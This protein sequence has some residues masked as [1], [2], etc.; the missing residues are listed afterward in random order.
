MVT[1]KKKKNNSNGMNNNCITGRNSVWRTWLVTV[2]SPD[3][4]LEP[5]LFDSSGFSHFL[6]SYNY[7]SLKAL[8]F[9]ECHCV[10][11]CIH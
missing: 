3:G 4:A 10:M 6:E 9:R 8:Q 7:K 1:V 5:R 11:Y 2:S